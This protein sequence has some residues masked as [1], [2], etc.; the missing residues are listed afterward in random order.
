MNPVKVNVNQLISISL[1]TLSLILF[2]RHKSSIA[3]YQCHDYS[4]SKSKFCFIIRLVELIQRAEHNL[5]SNNIQMFKKVLL[6][7]SN[8]V[9]PIF[10][11]ILRINES[12]QSATVCHNYTTKKNT[13]NFYIYDIECVCPQF[14][15]IHSKAQLIASIV[16]PD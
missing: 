8:N 5:S 3:D 16:S 10:R 13:P 6:F 15:I 4:W 14:S 9:H 7:I 11:N 12:F 2:V 1:F